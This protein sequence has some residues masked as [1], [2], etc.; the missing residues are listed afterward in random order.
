MDDACS[1][2]D[3]GIIN[4]DVQLPLRGF[5]AARFL[6]FWVRML[7]SSDGCVLSCRGPCVGL[8]TRPEWFSRNVGRPVCVMRGAVMVGLD[9]ERVG[10]P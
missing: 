6:I 7:V 5:A 1:R 2:Q 8:I 10:T 9:P 4:K 3:Q